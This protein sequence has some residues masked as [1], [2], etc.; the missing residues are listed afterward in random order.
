MK[1]NV[2]KSLLSLLGL[3]LT[4]NLFAQEAAPQ[5]ANILQTDFELLQSDNELAK[6]LKISGY[7]Q[8]QFQSADTAGV[9]TMAG[10]NFGGSIDN[11][12]LIRRG[13][14]KFAYE[15]D[16]AQG[17]LQFDLTEK[18]MALKDAYISYLDP[19]MN[20]FRLTS[21]V[22]DRPFGYEI[23]YS[24]SARE[25]PE[26]S[27]I[28]QTLFPG[29]RD[30]GAKLTLQAPKTSNWNFIKLDLGLFN[31]N[32]IAVETDRYKDFIGHLAVAK[33]SI[34]E[35]MKWGV[36]ASYYTGGFASASAKSYSLKEVGG[37]NVYMPSTVKVGDKTHREYIGMDGQLSYDWFGG[38]SQIRGEYLFGSQ[39]GSSS[40]STSL[41]AASSGDIY[42]RKFNGW[43]VYF[44]QN[45]LETPIQFVVK[46]DFY[47]PNTGV[48]GNQIGAT[49]VDAASKATGAA[50]IAYSTLGLGFNVRLNTQM[51]LMAYYDIVRNETT[52]RIAT[53]STLSDLSHDRK[54]NVFTLRLQ[55]KF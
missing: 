53:T 18:G 52:S 10:G 9:V 32:G 21:G 30:L 13:R 46:Y 36:G 31:G 40:S 44:I 29:E 14:L 25:T 55:Y 8:A 35:R 43:Y 5:S 11:R 50:D 15:Y 3:L 47:D 20:Y 41:T 34:D 27:R 39:P 33:T 45:I 49:S 6:R 28:F 48:S 17:V 4:L 2:T 1:K 22:F 51:K 26:R 12:M 16:N 23:S 37:V 7:I 38:I 19:W 42:N 54:D 24:S